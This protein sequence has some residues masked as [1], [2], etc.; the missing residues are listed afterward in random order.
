VPIFYEKKPCLT[1]RKIRNNSFIKKPIKKIK[2]LKI[3]A[4]N[5][6]KKSFLEIFIYKE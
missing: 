6:P 5:G 2:F 1:R 4:K 3:H